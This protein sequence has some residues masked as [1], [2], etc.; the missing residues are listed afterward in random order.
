MWRRPV[1]EVFRPNR[2]LSR[3][4]R[5]AAIRFAHQKGQRAYG[6]VFWAI[7]AACVAHSSYTIAS[8]GGVW[9]MPAFAVAGLAAMLLVGAF[10]CVF[11]GYITRGM[12]HAQRRIRSE[13]G[14]D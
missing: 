12:L 5:L 1:G 10:N 3:E 14:H 13:F 11:H 6:A 2:E 9:V 7:V 4:E 8:M